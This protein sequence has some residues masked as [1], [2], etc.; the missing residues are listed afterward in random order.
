MNTQA[1]AM[2][3]RIKC[4]LNSGKLKADGNYTVP[5]LTAIIGTTRAELSDAV[6]REFGSIT[7]FC[8]HIGFTGMKAKASC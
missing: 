2:S 4:A 3:H 8:T 7:A 5:T 1:A 6:N